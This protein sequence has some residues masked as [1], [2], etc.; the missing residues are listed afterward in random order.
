MSIPGKGRS[1]CTGLQVRR[2]LPPERNGKKADMVGVEAGRD[3][4]LPAEDG[5]QL[6]QRG[7]SGDAG[8]VT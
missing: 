7:G 5:V 1:E 4:I 6:D 8:K 2:S 3:R